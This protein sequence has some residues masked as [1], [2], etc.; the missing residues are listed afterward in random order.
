MPGGLGPEALTTNLIGRN[1]SST[2]NS[3]GSAIW[4]SAKNIKPLVD[5]NRHTETIEVA[6]H[7]SP[8]RFLPIHYRNPGSESHSPSGQTILFGCPLELHTVGGKIPPVLQYLL[9]SAQHWRS[10]RPFA[11][12]EVCQ[13][14]GTRTADSPYSNMKQYWPLVNKL[15]QAW[16]GVEENDRAIVA[17]LVSQRNHR[18]LI[19]VCVFRYAISK[20]KIRCRD[21][22]WPF[23]SQYC[24]AMISR[25]PRWQFPTVPS[26]FRILGVHTLR[27]WLFSEP[28]PLLGYMAMLIL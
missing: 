13:K 24:Q 2:C 23:Q 27:N 3:S 19:M 25:W 14:Q 10:I 6:Y 15:E 4:A 20:A 22:L 17:R 11:F 26:R 8:I 18:F 5:A 16:T 7:R 9:D 12:S 28:W 1:L 21:T